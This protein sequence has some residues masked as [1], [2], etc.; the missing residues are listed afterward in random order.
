MHT[1]LILIDVQESFRQR[2]YWVEKAAQ[3]FL[4]ECNA[5]V[6]AC[7]AQKIPVVRTAKKKSPS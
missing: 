4:T 7:I 2:P 3:P 6:A 1:A 5:L